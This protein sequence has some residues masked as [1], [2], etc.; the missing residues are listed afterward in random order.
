MATAHTDSYLIERYLQGDHVQMDELIRRHQARAYQYAF[1]LTRD[2]DAAADLVAETFLRVFRSIERFKGESSFTTWLYRIITNCFLD[3]R[4]RSLARPIVSLD[5]QVETADG[6]VAMQ[7]ASDVSSPDELLNRR[8]R[9]E[10]LASAIEKLST[11]SRTIVQMFHGEMLSYE[12]IAEVLGIP[13]GTVKSRL[14]RAR[15]TLAERLDHKRADLM[16]A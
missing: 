5:A 10:M 13:A 15:V 2:Q 7:F 12:E 14:N 9:A 11:S 4:K 8:M 1:R 3:S 6:T 16:A